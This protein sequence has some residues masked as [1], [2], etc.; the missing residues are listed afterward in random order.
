MRWFNGLKVLHD[1][2]ANNSNDVIA[3]LVEYEASTNST[4]NYGLMQSMKHI[5]TTSK[6]Q[7]ACSNNYNWLKAL[8]EVNDWLSAFA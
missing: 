1:P 4:Q 5:S 8:D 2:I 3:V 6:K 7:F